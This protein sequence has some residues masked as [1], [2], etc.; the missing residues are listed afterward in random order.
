MSEVSGLSGASCVSLIQF[1]QPTKKT[2][3][4]LITTGHLRISQYITPVNLLSH[5]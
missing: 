4:Y 3:I 5:Y 2:K 1:L